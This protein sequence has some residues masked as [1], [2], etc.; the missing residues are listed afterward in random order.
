MKIVLASK[1]PRRKDLLESAGVDFE[2]VV[3]DKDEII[4]K[5]KPDEIVCELA[6]SKADEVWD[7]IKHKEG[8]EY[9]GET[10]VIAADTLVFLGNL[11][12]GKPKGRDDAYSMLK[13]LS[14]KTHQVYT[15][16]AI[17]I[18][19]ETITRRI[20]F[21]EKTDVEFFEISDEE[22]WDY[23][24]SG[25]PMDKAGAYAIQTGFCKHIKG[26]KGDYAN[27]V[28]LPLSRVYQEIKPYLKGRKDNV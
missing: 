5:E 6:F 2:I 18:G 13:M 12:L 4:T 17:F 3:S 16:V 20:N 28:G 26:I 23:I 10:M 7:K 11:H 8:A 9:E 27:V 22:I 25:E 21:Y 19:N 15:G 24:D 1:S 14:G